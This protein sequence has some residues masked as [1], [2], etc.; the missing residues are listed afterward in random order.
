MVRACA[1]QMHKR[2][3]LVSFASNCEMEIALSFVNIYRGTPSLANTL[4]G[5]SATLSASMFLR[6]QSNCIIAYHKMYLFPA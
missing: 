6:A 5:Y 2:Q 1:Y 4:I 3:E